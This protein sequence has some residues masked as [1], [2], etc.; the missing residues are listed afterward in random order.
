MGP[1]LTQLLAGVFALFALLSVNSVYLLSVRLLEWSSGMVYQNWFYLIMFLVHLVLGFI[2][3][4]PV[5]VFGVI[6]IMN[7]HDRK[8]RRAVQVGY[9]LFVA[10]II[11]LVSGVV[12]TRIDGVIVINDETIRS[13]A[14]WSHVITPVVCI[15]LYIIHRL[16]GRR[17]RWRV[18]LTWSAVTAAIA[19]P[20]ILLQ[21]QDPRS[22]NVAGNTK[23]DEYFF[24]S[25]SRTVTGDFISAQ[26]L[27]NN[28]YC[29]ECHEDVHESWLYSAHKN[30]SFNN[31]A[32]L[33]SVRGSRAALFGRD[34]TTSGARFCAGCHDPVILLSGEFDDPRFDDP[35]YDLSKD[36]MANSGV[37]CTVCHAITHVN[38][39]RGNGDYT[40]EEPTQ[41][42][43]TFSENPILKWV[44]RQLVKAKPDFHNMTFLK[45]LHESA[46]FCGACHK[47]HLPP[48]LN[49][50]KWL[51]GQNLYDSFL[52]SGVSGHGVSSFYYPDEAETGCNKCHM[53]LI[54]SEDFAA[55]DFD[56]SGLLTVHDHMF[57]SANT[58][59]AQ[60]LDMPESVIQSHI[61][62]NEGVMRVDIFGVREEGAID[63]KLTAPIRPSIPTLTPGN[64]YLIETV[65]RTLK[66]G[67]LFTEGTADSN[68]V[69]MD[70]TVT[71][72]GRLIGRSG[73]RDPDDNAV[74]PWAH[75]VNAFVIDRKGNRINR[76]NGE[77]IFIAL[78]NH[79]IPPGAADV[80]QY[81]L[82]IPDDV[83]DSITVDVKLQYRKFDT[84]YMRFIT[85]ESVYFN[86]LP[87]MTLAHDSVTF[88]VDGMVR[89]SD[90]PDTGNTIAAAS[91]ADDFPV[92]QRWNDYGIGLLRKG[93]RGQLRQA[94]YAFK[95]V[96]K[97]GQPDGPINL[98]RVYLKEGRVAVEA[99]EALRKAQRFDPPALQ[100]SL[101]WFTGLV[102]KQNGQLDDAIRNFE[103]IL[104]G[105]FEQAKGRGFDF[106]ID[107]RLLNELGQ[108]LHERAK[109][110]RGDKRRTSRVAIL[111]KAREAFE[112]TLVIDPENAVAHYSLKQVYH[113]LGD[114]EK[115]QYHGNQHAYFKPDDNAR[116]LA[117]ANARIKYPAANHAAEEITIYDLQRAENYELLANANDIGTNN[118]N[119]QNTNMQ[120]TNMQNTNVKDNVK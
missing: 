17:I 56:D 109:Q 86:D 117:I 43:F 95:Q 115:S 90:A 113:D 79:Q 26:V 94:E 22:W 51:R 5:I 119:M 99:P 19:V 59:L 54:E 106:T 52:L 16:A 25:L 2:I 6:H 81:R 71:S 20:M 15:W 107:Y 4:V 70:V 104:E 65:I 80:I 11:L 41:Y 112:K 76:R 82:R 91:G 27:D 60:L 35:E 30:A 64:E 73:G 42:P 103:Q 12:L 83:T 21:S 120:N 9:A 102:N 46:E 108:T 13:I 10:A 105:G 7:T 45:P 1:Q 50:Y 100:W 62:F 58:G 38:S 78:Y 66:M 69:W 116:D 93:V 101:L 34:G 87:I 67:H 75:R 72:G 55:A 118:T 23:G 31:P 33:F 92:W 39:P 85:G 96:E 47:V 89:T 14:Y 110:E 111:N 8:N 53:P 48:E 98:A 37:T 68:E 88:P 44:N 29:R 28:E 77:D 32:Y 40:I 3:I 24:P 36:R 63:G 57:P 97:L 114:I 61:D 49:A 84:E 18:G 74:D